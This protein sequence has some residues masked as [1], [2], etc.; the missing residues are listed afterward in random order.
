MNKIITITPL[1]FLFYSCSQLKQ[2]N[3]GTIQFRNNFADGVIQ[4]RDYRN[5]NSFNTFSGSITN[6]APSTQRN[7]WDFSFKASPSVHFTRFKFRT[8]DTQKNSADEDIP[9]NDINYQRIAFL[10]NLKALKDTPYGRIAYTVGAGAGVYHITDNDQLDELRVRSV[11]KLGLNH[12]AFISERFFIRVG[13]RAFFEEGLNIFQ[14][15]IRL[16]YFW[17]SL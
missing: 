1:L 14:V 13:P 15:Q 17:G 16:G 7:E 4:G 9:L 12:T 2:L 11:I 5:V 6:A 3:S 10:G 8:T